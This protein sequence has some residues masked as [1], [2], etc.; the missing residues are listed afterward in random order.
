M[1]YLTIKKSDAKTLGIKFDTKVCTYRNKFNHIHR[2]QRKK[3]E[4]EALE[5]FEKAGKDPKKW[6]CSCN[7]NGHEIDC[8]ACIL[9]KKEMRQYQKIYKPN[10]KNLKLNKSIEFV[11]CPFDKNSYSVKIFVKYVVDDIHTIQE[12]QKKYQTLFSKYRWQNE[13]NKL[14]QEK[15]SD[16]HAYFEALKHFLIARNNKIIQDN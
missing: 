16:H 14:V 13:D 12:I 8:D 5:R 7:F 6:L 2:E 4:K 10:M 15:H 1:E 11:L 3:K 9:N